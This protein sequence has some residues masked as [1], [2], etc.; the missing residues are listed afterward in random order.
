MNRHLGNA[1]ILEEECNQ[2]KVLLQIMADK[3]QIILQL[4]LN[5]HHQDQKEEKEVTQDKESHPGGEN[6]P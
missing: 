4:S 3:N 1:I 6:H 2:E 5:L